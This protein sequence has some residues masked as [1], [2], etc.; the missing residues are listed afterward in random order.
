MDRDN[1]NQAFQKLIFQEKTVNT[2]PLWHY[3]NSAVWLSIQNAQHGYY[4]ST[5]GVIWGFN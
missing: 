1:Y 4:A 2:E 3:Q 5:N